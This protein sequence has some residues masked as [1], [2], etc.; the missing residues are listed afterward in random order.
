MNSADKPVKKYRLLKRLEDPCGVVNIGVEKDE[1]QWMARFAL[2][3][4]GDCEIKTDWFEEVTDTPVTKLDGIQQDLGTAI[5]F[6]RAFVELTEKGISP[7]ATRDDAKKVI[8]YY[9]SK[10]K[11]SKQPTDTPKQTDIDYWRRELKKCQDSP[12]YFFTK[13]WTVNGMQPTIAM[14]EKQFNEVFASLSENHLNQTPLSNTKEQVPLFTIEQ[15]EDILESIIG[16]EMSYDAYKR[17][18]GE[19]SSDKAKKLVE[20]IKRKLPQ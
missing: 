1:W 4:P 11:A 5:C 19:N 17:L 3:N 18:P 7:D 20:K 15:L 2:L 14:S 12:Y 10:Y 16:S 9:E 8:Q 6:L 13:Y